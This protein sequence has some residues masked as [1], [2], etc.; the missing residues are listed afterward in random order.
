MAFE[1]L[2]Y[3]IALWR[4][5][6][7]REQLRRSYAKD[8]EQARA[9]KAKREEIDEIQSGEMHEHE[10]I[11]SEIAELTNVYWIREAEKRLVPRPD[12]NDKSNWKEDRVTGRPWLSDKAISQLR[13]E[14]RRERREAWEYW[15]VRGSL[16]IGVLGTI[17][18]IISVWKK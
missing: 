16:L 14:V 4:L 9:R 1:Y 11:D 5:H 15:Q 10:L 2:K 7:Q 17:I 8:L 3:R 6:R 12:Y 18:G 13:S